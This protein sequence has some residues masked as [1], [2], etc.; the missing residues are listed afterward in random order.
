MAIEVIKVDSIQTR[1]MQSFVNLT[2]LNSTRY[3]ATTSKQIQYSD[4]GTAMT[5][6]YFVYDQFAFRTA[7]LSGLALP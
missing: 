3:P 5:T 7:P 1:L 6:A 4:T 2:Q